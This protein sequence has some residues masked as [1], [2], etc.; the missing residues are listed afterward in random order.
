MYQRFD[1]VKKA[2]PD[3]EVHDP[4]LINGKKAFLVG[5]EDYHT[6]DTVHNLIKQE[7]G[8]LFNQDNDLSCLKILDIK[9]CLKNQSVF[10]A[11]LYMPESMLEMIQSKLYG[12]LYIGYL[13]CT[14]Y[15]YKPHIRCFHCQQHGHM[16]SKCRNTQTCVKC[17]GGHSVDTCNS[18]NLKCV[19]CAN[20]PE[21]R[22][23]A[24]HR[25]DSH[26]CPI[27]LKYRNDQ[28]KN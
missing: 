13:R 20:S 24:N 26:E 1:I 14:V 18:E 5:L 7:Y 17:G 23:C 28:T 8:T 12:K 3:L 2:L 4:E 9:P 6:P 19:N 11:T 27:F 10:R 22:H 15:P 21:H 25:A 16:K